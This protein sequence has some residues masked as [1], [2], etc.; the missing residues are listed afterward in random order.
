MYEKHVTLQWVLRYSIDGWCCLLYGTGGLVISNVNDNDQYIYKCQAY[1]YV[2][3]QTTGGSYYR[4][5]V[6]PGTSRFTLQL[7][8][9]M[10]ISHKKHTVRVCF[11]LVLSRQTSSGIILSR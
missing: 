2:L 7:P 3:R 10:V 11:G 5:I 8:S 1:N 6:E 9:P 4:L